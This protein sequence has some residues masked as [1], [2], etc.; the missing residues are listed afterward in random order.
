MGSIC[1]SRRTSPILRLSL[2]LPRCGAESP[3]R[4]AADCTYFVTRLTIANSVLQTPKIFI[5]VKQQVFGA[6]QIRAPLGRRFEHHTTT[7]CSMTRP[8]SP[9]SPASSTSLDFARDSRKNPPD[10]LPL[11]VSFDRRHCGKDQSRS[12]SSR[13]FLPAAHTG[14]KVNRQLWPAA[15]RSRCRMRDCPLGIF[16]GGGLGEPRPP[17]TPDASQAEAMALVRISRQIF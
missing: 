1:A 6:G 16:G 14:P 17:V 10:L 9:I 15:R 13:F 11:G 2:L 8:P 5:S 4:S 12:I 7:F 3:V